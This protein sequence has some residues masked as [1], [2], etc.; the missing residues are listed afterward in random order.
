MRKLLLTTAVVAAAIGL[1]ECSKTPP[2]ASASETS[3]TLLETSYGPA[4]T[5]DTF[6]DD[7]DGKKYKIVEIGGKKWMAKNMHYKP[8]T[9]NFWCYHESN[10]NCEEYGRLYD[11]KTAKTVCPSGW[12]LPTLEEWDS[13][14]YAVGGRKCMEGTDFICGAGWKLKAR[15]GWESDEC[16][17]GD[18]SDE[19]GFSALPGGN[20][21]HDDGEFRAVVS[22]GFWWTATEY[23]R[24]EAY[25]RSMNYLHS[26]LD[27]TSG[28]KSRA[29]SVRCV[30]DGKPLTEEE[31]RKK[32]E[33]KEEREKRRVEAEEWKKKE[34]QRLEK[35]SEYFIDSRNG[36]KYRAVKIGGKTWMA[37]NLNYKPQTGN[38]WCYDN[39]DIN[40]RRYGRMY[41]WSAAAT[42]CPAG[43]H[44]PSRKEWGDLS[45][46]VG[47]GYG[48]N[49]TYGK[50]GLAGN[51]LRA[52]S[53]WV[54]SDGENASNGDEYGFS[55]LPGGSRMSHCGDF[56]GIDRYGI[57]W[58]ATEWTATEK[59]DRFAFHRIISLD[60]L[61][62]EEY[63]SY[64][65][66]DGLSVRCV[67][68]NP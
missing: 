31:T 29:F 58:T 35:M 18:G 65:T 50:H 25:F 68:D 37:E 52:A 46:A 64:K 36:R 7:R 5:Y 34:M 48:G 40:C 49:D 67:A 44:L 41:D 14:G 55:A 51:N 63:I 30:H 17:S 2:H 39:D 6:T 59:N 12:H 20:R 42:A 32:A 53:G 56:G 66:G 15:S 43:W 27:A 54:Y 45:L 62:L 8:E 33:E 4:V 22:H 3:D 23:N 57:W 16:K 28:T 38:T 9:G 13:L 11:W 60:N 26:H 10:S 24:N 47:G 1:A 21:F 61:R 19:Y